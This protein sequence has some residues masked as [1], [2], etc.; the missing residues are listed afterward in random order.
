MISVRTKQCSRVREYTVAQG[1]SKR[2]TKSKSMV[3]NE[4]AIY[5]MKCLRIADV[6]NDRTRPGD[7][8][9][10]LNCQILNALD[11]VGLKESRRR[12][13]FL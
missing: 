7:G 13:K 10:V 11:I 6:Q 4:V 1:C 8:A 3:P 2:I 5:R 9:V 12:S